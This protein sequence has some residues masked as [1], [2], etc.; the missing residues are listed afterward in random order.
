MRWV[1]AGLAAVLLALPARSFPAPPAPMPQPVE[2]LVGNLG[3]PAFG[4]REKAQRELWQRGE[5]SIPA[6][7]KAAAGDD[8]E[9]AR[10]A[11][12]LIDKFAWGVRPDTPPAVLALIR[13]FRAGDPNPERADTVRK[14]AIDKLLKSGPVGVS[15]VRAILKKELPDEARAKLT[16]SVT[17]QLR[18]DVPLLLVAGNRAAADELIGLHAAGTTPAGAADFAAY[19]VLRGDLPAVIAAQ[20]AAIEAGHKTA[21]ARLVLVHL[22]RAAG[23]WAKARAA[24]ADLPARPDDTSYDEILLEDAGDWRALVTAAP[25]REMNHPDAVRL[26]LLRLAGRADQ[27]NT[28][29]KKVRADA[30]ELIAPTDVKDAAVALLANH[31]AAAA[32]DLLLEK[33]SNLALLSEILIARMR[34][35]EAL[36]LIGGKKEAETITAASGWTSTCAAPAC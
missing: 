20:E 5:E 3:H 24:A 30:D 14:E 33:R 2:E 7:K 4:V 9:A 13:R 12:E 28:L 17:A 22:Y 15:V 32:T 16:A 10:R 23:Q 6:L 31:R 36:D 19:H 34:Y 8:P 27:F 29:A 11:R 21:G 18:R 26:T 35:K 1:P 25:G